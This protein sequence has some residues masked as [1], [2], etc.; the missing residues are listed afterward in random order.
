M[1]LAVA[2]SSVCNGGGGCSSSS[3]SSGSSSNPASGNED[4]ALDV[5]DYSMERRS[6]SVTEIEMR[7][8]QYC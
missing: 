2:V 1:D 3:S 7:F 5:V 6:H 4:D 8:R